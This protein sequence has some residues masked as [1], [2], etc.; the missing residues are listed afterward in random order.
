MKREKKVIVSPE[1]TPEEEASKSEFY[2]ST[3]TDNRYEVRAKGKGLEM[4]CVSC[5][6]TVF[7]GET[8]EPKWV[9]VE[10]DYIDRMISFNSF[11]KE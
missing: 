1:E 6:P 10:R 3:H 9:P 2:I 7:A 5:K 8:I 11:V 4:K